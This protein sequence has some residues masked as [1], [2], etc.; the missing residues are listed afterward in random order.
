MN[1]RELL[2]TGLAGAAL[3]GAGGCSSLG[4]QRREP[5]PWRRP[6]QLVPVEVSLDR[7]IRTTV[8]LRPSRDSGFVLRADKLDDCMLIH[9]YGHGGAGMSLSWG[10]AHLAADLA[11][12]HTARDA[13]VIGCGVVGLTTARM[14]QRRGF[15]VTIYARALPPE[16]TSNMSWASFTPTSGLV[17]PQRRTAAWDEQF[18]KAVDIAYRELQ[19]LV[20]RRIGLSWIDEY[21]PMQNLPAGTT[22]LENG[23]AVGDRNNGGDPMLPDGM[24]LGREVLGPGEHPFNTRYARRRP[25]LKFEPSVYLD[26]LMRDVITFGGRIVVR[27]FGTPRDLV[28]LPEQLIVNCT[29]LGSKQLFGDEELTPVRGQLVILAP[30][31]DV[32]YMVGGM[33]PRGD[34]IALGHTMERGVWSLEVDEAA[35]DRVLEQH[36]RTFHSMRGP[37]IILRVP[38]NGSP[39]E[40]PPPVESFFDRES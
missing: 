38:T 29:G 14:L 4:M 13:A 2:K 28:A 1:R 39:A 19:L 33:L 35:R 7:V 40:E 9:N 17:S 16:T 6:A 37:D 5:A 20:G 12:L 15:T 8:G 30:Q 36:M 31:W 34:G 27:N 22:A 18:R 26:A 32:Q 21:G 23:R 3:I 25:T 10:T 11:L 24:I